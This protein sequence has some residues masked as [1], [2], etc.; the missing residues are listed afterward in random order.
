MQLFDDGL[1]CGDDAAG[2]ARS[3]GSDRTNLAGGVS[4]YSNQDFVGRQAWALGGM[5]DLHHRRGYAH[6]SSRSFD[7]SAGV[8]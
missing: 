8:G 2:L 5:L 1:Y 6:F 7:E 3:A 4:P